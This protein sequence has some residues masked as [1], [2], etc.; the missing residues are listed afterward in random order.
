MCV[1]VKCNAWSLNQRKWHFKFALEFR[2]RRKKTIAHAPEHNNNTK[3][4]IG[5][6]ALNGKYDRNT[7]IMPQLRANRTVCIAAILYNKMCIRCS[8][9]IYDQIN[10]NDTI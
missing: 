8:E 2:A 3:I 4:K 10:F 6:G 5:C 9:S 1:A 7:G